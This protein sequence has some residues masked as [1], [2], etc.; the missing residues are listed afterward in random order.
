MRER[1]LPAADRLYQLETQRLA[2]DRGGAAAFPW[3]TVPLLLLTLAGL[4]VTQVYLVRRTR[5]LVN[6]GLAAA[7]AA[8][9]VLLLWVGLSWIGAAVNLNASDRDGSAQV[10]VLAQARIAALQARADEALT[11]VARGQRRRVRGGLQDQLDEAR[12]RGRPGR[13]AGARA[14]RRHRSRPSG[15]RWR[16]AVTAVR[17]S[18]GR[19]T[20]SCA[21]STTPASTRRRCSWPSAPTAARRRRRSTVDDRLAAAIATASR[22]FDERADS[23]G[24]ALAGAGFGWTVLTLVLR[25]RRRGRPAAANRGVPMRE[26]LRHA[27]RPAALAPSWPR[28]RLRSRRV[29]P[30][31]ARRRSSHRCP[32]ACRTRR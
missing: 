8:G 22:A 9:L 6:V 7:T 19:C 20:T 13:A 26:S 14:E 31:A 4:A 12:R 25:R 5:R 10:E 16:G 30:V 24:G 17:T 3:L 11:L 2:D 28:C 29:E 18:G 23:A 15:T 27:R 21:A 1:L 32:P